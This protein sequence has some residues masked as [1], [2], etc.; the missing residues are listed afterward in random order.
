MVTYKYYDIYMTY[1][2]RTGWRLGPLA[3]FG[4]SRMALCPG[5]EI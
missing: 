1:L 3:E 5:A 2:S 4:E